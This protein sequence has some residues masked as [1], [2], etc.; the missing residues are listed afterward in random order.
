MNAKRELKWQGKTLDLSKPVIMGILNF[1]P[2]SFYDGGKLPEIR[3]ALDHAMEMVVQGA[4]IIDIGAVSSKPF[5]SYVSA[6]EEWERLS[7]VLS[8][9]RSVLPQTILS[10][11]TF[12]AEIARRA[13]EA[14]ADMIN[15]ISGG[16]MDADMFPLIARL[17]IPY[18]MMHMQGTP[19][20]MQ[21]DP[22]YKDVV[23]EVYKFFVH[24]LDKLKALGSNAPVILDPGFGFGK[25]VEHNY[26]LLK[27]LHRFQSLECPILAGISRKSMINKIL[28]IKPDDALNGTTVLNTLCLLQGAD[29]LRVH[30][31]KETRQAILL[32]DYYRQI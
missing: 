17:G 11:D 1:T 24:N 28:G 2:D 8:G 22:K 15:D 3:Y 19:Q 23:E 13:A 5:A 7:G 6:D 27:S 21:N 30:D 32:V 16:Q 20:T 26:Q 10:V 12:R 31:V 29:I 18:I 25:S 14:G 9:L 4:A